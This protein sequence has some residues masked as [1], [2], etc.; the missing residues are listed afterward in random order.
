[1]GILHAARLAFFTRSAASAGIMSGTMPVLPQLND[2]ILG[3]GCMLASSS[4]RDP[5]VDRLLAPISAGPIPTTSCEDRGA[6]CHHG[7]T[8]AL[9]SQHQARVRTERMCG[10]VP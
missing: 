6:S 5:P 10:T 1:M 2:A 9:F 7:G 4:E 3:W 8:H